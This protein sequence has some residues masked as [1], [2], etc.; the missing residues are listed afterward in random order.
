MLDEFI[1]WNPHTQMVT[2]KIS[3]TLGVIKRVRKFL[4]FHALE[5]IYNALVVP[6]L[7]YG[8]KLWGTN[9]AAVSKVQKRAIRLITNSRFFA[10]TSP[11][12]KRNYILKVEDMYKLQCLKLYYKI[13]H[14]I[15]PLYVSNLTVH[16]RQV[17][18]HNTRGR[19]DIR[20]TDIKSKWLR[21][22]LPDLII[23]TPNHIIR[24]INHTSIDTFSLHATLFYLD[25]YE[26]A[27]TLDVCLVCGR[28]APD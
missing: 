6:H 1:S 8:L 5:K 9:L 7:N 28:T 19:D 22:S 10:H 23:K 14:G 11:L 16:N 21:H 24:R 3:R 2:S 18:D 25:Q 20:P 26:L 4:P 15:A 27:C 17:H 13:Q 12:F